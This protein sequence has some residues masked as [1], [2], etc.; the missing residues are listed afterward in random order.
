[1][2]FKIYLTRTANKWLKR[3]DGSTLLI[4]VVPNFELQEEP[5]EQ[6]ILEYLLYKE[7]FGMFDVVFSPAPAGYVKPE[8]DYLGRILFDSDHNWA[9]DG[10][11][12]TVFEE[13]QVAEFICNF[14]H[15]DSGNL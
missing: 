7:D 11:A 14:E 5:L 2:L 3:R 10:E 15:G 12:L 1:M 6:G 13:E 4:R 8:P 9:Y